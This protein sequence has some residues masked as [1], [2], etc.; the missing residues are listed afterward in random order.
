MQESI[1]PIVLASFRYG[2]KPVPG[3]STFF[4]AEGGSGHKIMFD[5]SLGV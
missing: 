1:K 2:L 4:R 5:H 3:V